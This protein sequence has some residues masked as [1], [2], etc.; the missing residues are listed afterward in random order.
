[1]NLADHTW[2]MMSLDD[3]YGRYPR[4]LTDKC[5]TMLVVCHSIGGDVGTIKTV[6]GDSL[7]EVKSV[8]HEHDT[9]HDTEWLAT[10]DTAARLGAGC[11]R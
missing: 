11:M 8:I 6:W 5:Y 4:Y 2:R 7:D 1:M 3:S 9:A 10:S